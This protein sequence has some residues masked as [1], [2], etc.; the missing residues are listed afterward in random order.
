M[1]FAEFPTEVLGMMLHHLKSDTDNTIILNIMF[2][3]RHLY[4][5]GLPHLYRDVILRSIKG[6]STFLGSIQ[7]HGH[8]VRRLGVLDP[9]RATKAGHE[10]IFLQA[11]LSTIGEFCPNL[12]S[13]YFHSNYLRETCFSEPIPE[14]D[15]QS[16]FILSSAVH[17]PDDSEDEDSDGSDD[18]IIT[19]DYYHP[20]TTLGAAIAKIVKNC[21]LE[22]LM[23]P[24]PSHPSVLRFRTQLSSLRR[25]VISYSGITDDTLAAIS[26][27][28][29]SIVGIRLARIDQ[30]Q[31][32]G[33]CSFLKSLAQLNV[34]EL[35]GL[36]CL[37]GKSSGTTILLQTLASSHPELHALGLVW[38]DFGNRFPTL[39]S[40]AFQNL[41]ILD[42]RGYTSSHYP[43][44]KNFV[45]FVE[46][47]PNLQKL[48]V[49]REESWDNNCEPCHTRSG[50]TVAIDRIPEKEE[51]SYPT[52]AVSIRIVK[53]FMYH[54]KRG[55]VVEEKEHSDV[56]PRFP[57]QRSMWTEW[58][59]EDSGWDPD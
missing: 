31:I 15:Q 46:S 9:C 49:M 33:L 2:I 37:K 4:H 48:Y 6:A 42:L 36:R 50:I 19:H 13:F 38:A 25:L 5:A 34:L 29:P 44:P 18:D 10:H 57:W 52:L 24:E 32:T 22:E 53:N 3:S 12:R 30:V 41:R 39:P 43:D 1:G 58:W 27:A 47:F 55:K 11:N 7:R 21:P 35:W 54:V 26:H 14:L 28:C 56:D 8:F 59:D 51:F 45:L 20:S 17:V 16:R 23:I 40:D